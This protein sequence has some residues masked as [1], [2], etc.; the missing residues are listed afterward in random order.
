MQGNI[1]IY[2]FLNQIKKWVVLFL[3]Q[4]LVINVLQQQNSLCCSCYV[5]PYTIQQMILKLPKKFS[6]WKNQC[7][8]LGAHL[9]YACM[10]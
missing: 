5:F 9:S 8:G 7:V 4:D 2:Q 6:I 3:S 10:D 1:T